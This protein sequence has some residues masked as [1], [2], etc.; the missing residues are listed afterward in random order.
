MSED[1]RAKIAP[2]VNLLAGLAAK[3]G[4]PM[5]AATADVASPPL[6]TLPPPETMRVFW[7]SQPEQVVARR[8]VTDGDTVLVYEVASERASMGERVWQRQP[9]PLPDEAIVTMAKAANAE[10]RLLLLTRGLVPLYAT[11]SD[12]QRSLLRDAMTRAG[13]EAWDVIAGGT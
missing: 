12:H 10:A 9:I 5:P 11:L 4:V 2:L 6:P 3:S 13:V 7:E 8:L 1:I